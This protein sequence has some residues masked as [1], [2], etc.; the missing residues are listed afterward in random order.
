MVKVSE[1]CEIAASKGNK[2]MGV[3]KLIMRTITY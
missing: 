2:I 1:L 3:I